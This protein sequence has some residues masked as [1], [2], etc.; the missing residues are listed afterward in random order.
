MLNPY[1]VLFLF[2]LEIAFPFGNSGVIDIDHENT[3]QTGTQKENADSHVESIFR[4][5]ESG[6][7]KGDVSTFSQYFG[8]QVSV[9]LHGAETGTF[10]SNQTFYIL[11]NYFTMMRLANFSFSTVHTT[12][13]TPFATGGGT[14]VKKGKREIVQIYVSLVKQDRKWVVT[15]FNVY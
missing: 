12:K 9:S 3:N 13:D 15:Q 1:I 10:S 11:Q 4:E 6:L 5:I 14:I 8:K 2:N 7:L